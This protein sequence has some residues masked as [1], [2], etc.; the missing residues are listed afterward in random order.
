MRRAALRRITEPQLVFPRVEQFKSVLAVRDLVAQI[1][2][3]AAVGVEIIEMLVQPLREQPRDHVEV[4]VV[5]RREP[6]RIALG[7]GGAAAFGGKMAR[8]F[9]FW[10][11]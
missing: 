2:R 11:S 10:C 3:P 6:A 5:M 8:D 4:L 1:V 7:F 9:E